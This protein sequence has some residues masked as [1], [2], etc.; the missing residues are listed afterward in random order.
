[1]SDRRITIDF[2]PIRWKG[3]PCLTWMAAG[4]AWMWV[5]ILAL[6]FLS[7]ESR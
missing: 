6:V 7:G 1:M 3:S 4:A 2:E 5:G